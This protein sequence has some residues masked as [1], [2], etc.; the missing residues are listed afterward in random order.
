MNKC[1][2]FY[3]S[4]PPNLHIPIIFCTFAENFKMMD[5]NILL[6]TSN[7][8][9][10]N[11]QVQYEDGAFWLTQKRMA[12]LFGVETN[13][14]NYHLK[15]IFRSE[16]LTENSVVRKIRITAADGKN[17]ATNFYHLDAIIAVGYPV[18]SK[19]ATHFRF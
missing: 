10:V 6:Y 2:T 19:Q 18:N 13:T 11:I 17:Y 12:E 5:S 1:K 15:E 8:G 4:T 14:I 7:A 9:D 3:F 16:E